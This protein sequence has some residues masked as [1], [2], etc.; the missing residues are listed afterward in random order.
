MRRKSPNVSKIDYVRHSKDIS[1]DHLH[2]LVEMFPP[3]TMKTLVTDAKEQMT[4]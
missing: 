4:T 2:K 3:E 1:Q